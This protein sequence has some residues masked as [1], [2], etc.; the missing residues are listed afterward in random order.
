MKRS[1]EN[2]LMGFDCV[3]ERRGGSYPFLST[4]LR[5][6]ADRRFR[7]GFRPRR[8]GRLFLHF[9]PKKLPLEPIFA[10]QRQSG[11]DLPDHP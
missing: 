7:S 5:H 11:R 1:I 9:P 8:S 4:I 3:T 10:L 6:G 2:S